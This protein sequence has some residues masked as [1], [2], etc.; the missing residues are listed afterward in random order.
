[1][2]TKNLAFDYDTR[3]VLVAVLSLLLAG[4]Y[5]GYQHKNF[6]ITALGVV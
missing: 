6:G 4:L 3:I 1:M 5:N 2:M